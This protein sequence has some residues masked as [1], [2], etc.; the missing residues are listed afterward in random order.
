MLTVS[1]KIIFLKNFCHETN[2]FA[3]IDVILHTLE[4]V[5][6]IKYNYIGQM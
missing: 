1:I 3:K 2:I 5:V 4:R 6:N